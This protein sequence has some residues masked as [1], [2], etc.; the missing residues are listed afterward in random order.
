MQLTTTAIS[1]IF[2]VVHVMIKVLISD[3][4]DCTGCTKFHWVY[5]LKLFCFILIILVKFS[6]L[7]SIFL[8]AQRGTNSHGVNP[9][10][11]SKHNYINMYENYPCIKTVVSMILRQRN[12]K[13]GLYCY[14][15]HNFRL[16]LLV[17][18][19]WLVL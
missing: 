11:F 17:F 18:I 5:P 7:W 6:C 16:K 3:K 14:T 1:H 9:L 13:A 19:L 15:F 2:F 10:L 12:N 4:I 8:V